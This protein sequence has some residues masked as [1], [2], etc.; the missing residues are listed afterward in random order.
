MSYKCVLKCT[1]EKNTG[2][3]KEKYDELLVC[4]MPHVYIGNQDYA[5]QIWKV[6]IALY[7]MGYFITIWYWLPN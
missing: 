6:N 2:T 4:L 5:S 7:I 3:K 1:Q